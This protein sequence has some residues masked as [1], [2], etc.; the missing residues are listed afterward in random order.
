MELLQGNGRWSTV[1]FF[2]SRCLFECVDDIC[3]KNDIWLKVD[4]IFEKLTI[5]SQSRRYI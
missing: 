2:V 5:Y 4:D 3:R 1:V